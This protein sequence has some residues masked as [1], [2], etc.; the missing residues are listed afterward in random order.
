MTRRLSG[1]LRPGSP[2]DQPHHVAEIEGITHSVVLKF[3][4]STAGNDVISAL[5]GSGGDD[6][7]QR[8][9]PRSRSA[10]S[11]LTTLGSFSAFAQFA[12]RRQSR[13]FDELRVGDTIA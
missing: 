7:S 10:S 2:S 13:S 9:M 5:P 12:L 11:L 6:A 4:M 3:E 8:R 1:T